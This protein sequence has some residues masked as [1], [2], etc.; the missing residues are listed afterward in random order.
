MGK[1]SRDAAS[2]IYMK[3][4]CLAQPENQLEIEN[5]LG[6]EWVGVHPQSSSHCL[7]FIY[8]FTFATLS[9]LKITVISGR[10]HQ[11]DNFLP[12]RLAVCFRSLMM[13]L[14]VVADVEKQAP[15]I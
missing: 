1:Y 13:D 5:L 9:P 3:S 15:C 14:S 6:V 2:W 8:A 4:L 11:N 12:L 7:N 10:I